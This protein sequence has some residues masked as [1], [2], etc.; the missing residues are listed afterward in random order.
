V[1]QTISQIAQASAGEE[2]AAVGIA[3]GAIGPNGRPLIFITARSGDSSPLINTAFQLISDSADRVALIRTGEVDDDSYEYIFG[4][5][6]VALEPG[7]FATVIGHDSGLGVVAYNVSDLSAT[8]VRPFAE[9][10]A[11]DASAIRVKAINSDQ[12]IVALRNGSGKLEL[13]GWQL[14]ARDF[15]VRRAADTASHPIEAQEV[16]LAV[17]GQRAVTAGISPPTF[18]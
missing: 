1:D 12:A 4:T 5:A 2:L 13:I 11:G 7:R 15:A 14:A 6:P 8:L 17:I 10:T 16:A 9:A 3:V 18:H